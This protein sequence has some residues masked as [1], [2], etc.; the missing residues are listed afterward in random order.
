LQSVSH[1]S[2]GIVPQICGRPAREWGHNAC[3][4]SLQVAARF[5]LFVHVLLGPIRLVKNC[6]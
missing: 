3:C 2:A 4:C 5:M 1:Y 6:N